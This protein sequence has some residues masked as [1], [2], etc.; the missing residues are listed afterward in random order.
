MKDAWQPF[1]RP[2]H[3]LKWA[4][5]VPGAVLMRLRLKRMM[6]RP[7]GR[8]AKAP[9]HLTFEPTRRC[10][11]NC[12]MC[13]I[14]TSKRR[15]KVDELDLADFETLLDGVRLRSI[16]LVGGE[17]FM[18]RDLFDLLDALRARRIRVGSLTTNGTLLDID[19]A[20]RIASFIAD[21]VLESLTLSLDGR[22][23]IHNTIRDSETAFAKLAQGVDNVKAA[24]AELKINHRKFMKIITTISESN[25]ST[26]PEV[27]DILSE[28]GLGILQI[29]H[30]VFA[31][32]VERDA[33]AERLGVA[34]GDIDTYVLDVDDSPLDPGAIRDGLI[35]VARKTGDAGIDLTGRPFVDPA[36]ALTYYTGDFRART[37]CPCPWANAR[38]GA[39]GDMS[40]CFLIRTVVGRARQDGVTAAWNSRRYREL[41][42]RFAGTGCLE[43]CKRCC[44]VSLWEET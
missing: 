5:R 39:D 38:I 37:Q 21:G 41:R 44:K 26:F 42:R 8:A 2:V 6:T 9:L 43:V 25:F 33:S 29:N 3:V 12:R 7:D 31:T 16:N 4:A 19:N 11:L 13:Y 40:F 30:L 14:D 24:L 18:R 17:P 1:H 36:M 32:P 15:G 27:V 22:E 23:E 20:R 10:N 35:E 34:P 28:W